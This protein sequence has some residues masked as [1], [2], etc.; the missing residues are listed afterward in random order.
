MFFRRESKTV[1]DVGRQ[2]W[3]FWEKREPRSF[4]EFLLWGE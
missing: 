1:L 4:P 3:F 2:R